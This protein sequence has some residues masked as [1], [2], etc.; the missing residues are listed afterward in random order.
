MEPVIRS[1]EASNNREERRELRRKIEAKTVS[2]PESYKWAGIGFI[3]LKYKGLEHLSFLPEAEAEYDFDRNTGRGKGL[4][5]L[6]QKEMWAY[7]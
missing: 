3:P 7:Q 5:P 2:V 1:F 6:R 4:V